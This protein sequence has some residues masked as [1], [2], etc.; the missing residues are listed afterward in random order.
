MHFHFVYP[1]GKPILPHLLRCQGLAVD[2]YS[3][4][5]GRLEAEATSTF[6]QSTFNTD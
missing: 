4:A 6:A 3:K 1:S 2:N 5:P